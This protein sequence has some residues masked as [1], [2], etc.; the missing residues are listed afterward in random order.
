MQQCRVFFCMK[1]TQESPFMYLTYLRVALAKLKTVPQKHTVMYPSSHP[2]CQSR[3]VSK[4]ITSVHLG[5]GGVHGKTKAKIKYYCH[6]L[7]KLCN[8]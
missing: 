7:Y 3:Q 2:R 5:A 8:F 1:D 6:K 4:R